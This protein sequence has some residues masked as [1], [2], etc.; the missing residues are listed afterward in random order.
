MRALQRGRAVAGDAHLVA[1]HPQRT[2]QDLG[3]RVVVLDDQ[4][5]GGTLEISHLEGR[6]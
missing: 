4:H 5:T 3:D 6:W 1:L 2:L